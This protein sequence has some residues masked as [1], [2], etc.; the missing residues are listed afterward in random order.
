MVNTIPS[1]YGKKDHLIPGK[2]NVIHEDLILRGMILLPPLH[3]KLVLLAKQFVK[4]FDLN[5]AAFHHTRNMFYHLLDAKVKGGI[6]T[7]SQA[8]VML[9]F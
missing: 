3:I 6:F 1:V 4:V 2:H 7:G 8:Q 9:A 5:S